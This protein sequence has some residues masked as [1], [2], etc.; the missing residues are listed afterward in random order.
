[1]NDETGNV[2]AGT[3]EG[4]ATPGPEYRPLDALLGRWMTTGH[5]FGTDRSPSAPIH[6]SDIY[7]WAPGGFFVLHTAYGTIGDQGV[8]GIE[9]IGYDAET[10]LFHTTF[11]D[12]QGNV[13]TEELSVDGTTWKWAGDEVRC[14]G[15]L[16]DDRRTMVCH[17]ERREG[18]SW[19]PSMDVTLT[20]VD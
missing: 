12:S 18:E 17:H 7:E 15:V 16:E 13:T 6:A 5:T 19:V 10:R 14:T 4:T 3:V 1:M 8:G 9:M 20:K 11:F 2:A